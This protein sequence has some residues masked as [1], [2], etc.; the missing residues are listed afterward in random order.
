MELIVLYVQN[1]PWYKLQWGKPDIYFLLPLYV[2][3]KAGNWDKKTYPL[4]SIK[5]TKQKLQLLICAHTTSY[6]TENRLSI[7]KFAPG[8]LFFMEGQT[9]RKPD[10]SSYSSGSVTAVLYINRMSRALLPFQDMWY[11]AVWLCCCG[12]VF[13]SSLQQLKGIGKVWEDWG[14]NHD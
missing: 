1:L 10:G 9:T 6:R 13:L 14:V 7:C 12:C 8:H 5:E 2:G 3:I 11:R 4:K